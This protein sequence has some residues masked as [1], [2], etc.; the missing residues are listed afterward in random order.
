MRTTFISI[1]LLMFFTSSC[2]ATFGPR[3][4]P[5][6]IVIKS[7]PLQYKIVKVKG[8]KYYY[9][10]ENHYRRVRGGYVLIRI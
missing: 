1:V 4:T 10:N 9:W 8:K 3:P 7:R 2:V 6:V 5:G